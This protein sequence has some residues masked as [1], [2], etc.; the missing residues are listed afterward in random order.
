[1]GDPLLNR[2]IRN[3][4]GVNRGLSCSFL[5]KWVTLRPISYV[6]NIKLLLIGREVVGSAKDMI[7]AT[8]RQGLTPFPKK[9]PKGISF[10]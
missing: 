3:L 8:I 5:S 10:P 2:A 4:R 9:L 6:P 1:M 7:W